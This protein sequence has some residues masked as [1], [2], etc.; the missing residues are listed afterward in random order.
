MIAVANATD[1]VDGADAAA[2]RLRLHSTVPDPRKI[3][4][5][6]DLLCKIRNLAGAPKRTVRYLVMVLFTRH[7]R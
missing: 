3:Y 4:A 5:P 6:A 1:A 7:A 2:R